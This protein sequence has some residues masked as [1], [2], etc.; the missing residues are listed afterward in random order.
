MLKFSGKSYSPCF[1]GNQVPNLKK[2]SSP[3]PAMGFQFFYHRNVCPWTVFKIPSKNFCFV[4]KHGRYGPRS[5]FHIWLFRKFVF[6]QHISATT[7]TKCKLF[8]SN[9]TNLFTI[10][11]ATFWPK[12]ITLSCILIKLPPFKDFEKHRH[13]HSFHNSEAI[14]IK[15]HTYVF[16]HHGKILNK[17]FQP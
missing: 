9:F 11:R 3:R 17:G 12:D 14:F 2:S 6:F 10:T 4:K 5:L 16:H 7:F 8:S 13:S 1:Y 15:L